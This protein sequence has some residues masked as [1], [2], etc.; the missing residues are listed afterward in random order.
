MCNFNCF[1]FWFQG[2]GFGSDCTYS[3]S[4]LLFTFK[5]LSRI[6]HCQWLFVHFISTIILVSSIHCLL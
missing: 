2:Q 3:W 1:Q 4:L 6:E 5:M